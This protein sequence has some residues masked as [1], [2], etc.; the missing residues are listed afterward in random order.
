[1][2]YEL[3]TIKLPEIKKDIFED[4]E[5]KNIIFTNIQEKQPNLNLGFNYY[6]HVVKNKYEEKEF[7]ELLK[8]NSKLRN[9]VN[10]FE[11]KIKDDKYKNDD[12]I[13]FLHKYFKLN[14]KPDILS[15]ALCK[16]WE[17]LIIYGLIDPKQKTFKSLH[18]AEGPG[19]FIQGTILFREKFV[20]NRE[21]E[22]HGVTLF[23]PSINIDNKFI[24]YYK[25][26]G[27]KQYDTIPTKE[28]M[29]NPNM[30]DGDLTKL[31]TLQLLKKKYG[32]KV[33]FD[34]ITGDGGFRWTNENYQEQEAYLLIFG[35]I[36]HALSFQA[37][38]GNFLLKI[39]EMF[40]TVTVKM[41]M[42]LQ[43]FYEEVYIT[44]PFTSRTTNSERYIIC[45]G[46]K[47]DFDD[48]K[49]VIKMSILKH[50]FKELNN[51][52]D[53]NLYV[54]ILLPN[55]GIPVEMM[56][57]I[58]KLN[59]EIANIQSIKINELYSFIKKGIYFGSSYSNYINQQ[60]EASKFWINIFCPKTV[61][62]YYDYNKK[63]NKLMKE[64]LEKLLE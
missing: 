20:K 6:Y 35:Q 17:C 11:H 33:K 60:V 28:A 32:D 14:K 61:D 26:H 59:T 47:Y 18:L 34:F 44:K 23:N 2:T 40:T 62:E 55:I 15:R 7:E 19:S 51:I 39:F 4:I 25:K 10:E 8:K 45:K 64:K 49:Y 29:K 58:T 43:T 53:K 22:Y 50:I 5:R 46:F 31:K 16:M 27:Y 24:K 21:D 30:S 57:V 56:N 42:L 38:N 9:I 12:I 36:I 54:E 48:E 3:K 41:T 52:K 1:M 13:T 63:L 37:K